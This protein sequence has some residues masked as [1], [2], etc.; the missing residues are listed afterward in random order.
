MNSCFVISKAL[1]NLFKP[2]NIIVNPIAY[3][4]ESMLLHFFP[5]L[6]MMR[7]DKLERFSLEILSSQVLEI[8]G[9]ARANPIGALFRC[10]L[11]E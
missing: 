3:W 11:L 2:S 4:Q 7:P 6:L 5:S 10:F 8:E 9:K 1:D